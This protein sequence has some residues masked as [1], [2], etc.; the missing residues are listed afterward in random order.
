[1]AAEEQAGHW[2]VA[3]AETA[4]TADLVNSGVAAVTTSSVSDGH[5]LI[6][7]D[8]PDLVR[9]QM[10]AAALRPDHLTLTK[11]V[12]FGRCERKDPTLA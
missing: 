9:C 12:P 11:E 6:G 7:V 1:M 2:P 8:H 4:A 10:P 5:D 3:A